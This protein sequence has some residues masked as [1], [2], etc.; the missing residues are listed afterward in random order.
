LNWAPGGTG[1]ICDTI[2]NCCA[3]S[4]VTPWHYLAYG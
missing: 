1:N 2:A 4:R 3:E